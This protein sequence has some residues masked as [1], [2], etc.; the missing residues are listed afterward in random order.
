M[1]TYKRNL[2][3]FILIVN[4]IGL[5]AFG[6]QDHVKD[7]RRIFP[8]DIYSPQ[9]KKIRDFYYMVNAAIDYNDF[10]SIIIRRVI[11]FA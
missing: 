1:E 11:H 4:S 5:Y 10:P 6:V 9:N 7:M 3:L 8:F 2:I